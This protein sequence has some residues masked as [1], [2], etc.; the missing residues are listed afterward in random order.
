MY[1]VFEQLLQKHNVSAYKVSKATGISQATLSDWKR[2]ISTPKIDKLQKIA[3]F[4]GVS[5][6]Y[7]RTGEQKEKQPSD[8][9]S[10]SDDAL[11]AAFYRDYSDKLS[12]SEVDELWE[13]A[14]E[15][16]QFKAR[17]RMNKKD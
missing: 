15:Y 14:K 5:L 17:Q 7:L 12:S 3:D 13:D 8:T 6:D 16:A 2:G 4:F 10:I 11:K 9:P 1:E